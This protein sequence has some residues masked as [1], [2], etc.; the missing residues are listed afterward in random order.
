M[1]LSLEIAIPMLR[2]AQ[3]LFWKGRGSGG[4]SP[5][6]PPLASSGS[7]FDSR[8]EGESA[9]IAGTWSKTHNDLNQNVLLSFL[10]S[11]D[12]IGG[13]PGSPVLVLLNELNES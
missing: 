2:D 13:E 11:L 12:T 8:P 6:V 9:F 10:A 7:I 3:V 1:P 4:G 5:A